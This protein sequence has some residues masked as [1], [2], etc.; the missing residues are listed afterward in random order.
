MTKKLVL[1][2]NTYNV[3]VAQHVFLKF[4]GSQLSVTI[5][6]SGAPHTPSSAPITDFPHAEY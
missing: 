6:H 4:T 2:P 3:V 5:S 1:I